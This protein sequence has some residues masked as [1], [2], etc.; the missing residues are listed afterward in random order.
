MTRQNLVLMAALGS[1]LMLA[2]AFGFQ[3]IGDMAPCK[4]CLWQRWPHAVAVVI[5]LL[6]MALPLRLWS[7]LGA[8]AA[9]TTAG[10]AFYHSG[11]E[12]S[13]WQG[14]TSCTSSGVGGLSVDDLMKQIMSAPVIR[15]DEI[16]W[17]FA[18]ISM[19]GWNG[20]VSAGLALIWLFSARLK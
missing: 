8:L 1:A 19:A 16:P 12:L 2:G 14:P 4:L 13:W 3:Y 20:I 17:S 18:G 11:V 15:C 10:I 9:A 5:G 6:A 7:Y